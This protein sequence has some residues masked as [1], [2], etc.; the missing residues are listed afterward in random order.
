[1]D[2]GL[3]DLADLSDLSQ[4][5]RWLVLDQTGATKLTSRNVRSADVSHSRFTRKLY[6]S[7]QQM[8]A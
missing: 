1:M 3:G 2:D 4:R 5:T 6:D 7:R 8:A